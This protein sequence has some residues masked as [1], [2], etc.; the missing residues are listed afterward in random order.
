MGG[1]V[2]G[3]GKLVGIDYDGAVKA[4]KEQAA[5]TMQA[6]QA[7]SRDAAYAAQA[8]SQ[9]QAT[10]ALTQANQQE[11]QQLLNQPT[12]NATV[13]LSSQAVSEAAGD[14]SDD[15]LRKRQGARGSYQAPA[16]TSG[17]VV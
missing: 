7:A 8:A 11:A 6:A 10:A 3:I 15:L 5:A 14:D 1:I 17:L 16:R 12:A 4:G 2:K 9:Q 13:D